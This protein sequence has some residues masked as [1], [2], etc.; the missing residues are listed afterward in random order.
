MRAACAVASE[1]SLLAY[2][3]NIKIGTLTYFRSESKRFIHKSLR[4]DREHFNPLYNRIT[5]KRLRRV[6]SQEIHRCM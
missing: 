1:P 2:A 4:H 3:T 6:Y 5:E